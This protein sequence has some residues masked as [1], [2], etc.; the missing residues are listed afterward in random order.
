M[1]CTLHLNKLESPSAKDNLHKAE[2]SVVVLKTFFLKYS[3]GN[4]RDYSSEQTK[5]I[6]LYPPS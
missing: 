6:P 3:L 2:I 4:G 1:G 5:K